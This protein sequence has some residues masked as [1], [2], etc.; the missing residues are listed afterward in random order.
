MSRGARASR[1]VLR[2]AA[3]WE[4]FAPHEDTP[5]AY[6]LLEV[7]LALWARRSQTT[8]R[9][10]GLGHKWGI[11]R[12]EEP[13]HHTARSRRGAVCLRRVRRG[14]CTVRACEVLTPHNGLSMRPKA[15]Q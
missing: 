3:S 4:I 1:Q 11:F 7:P 14:R 12:Q 2:E 15:L 9:A 5:P 10:F 13:G 6:A 8:T